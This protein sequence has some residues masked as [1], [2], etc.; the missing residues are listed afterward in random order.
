[1]AF[2]EN[3]DAY[4]YNAQT[5]ATTLNFVTLVAINTKFYKDLR[6][7]PSLHRRPGEAYWEWLGHRHWSLR[8]LFAKFLRR[9]VLHLDRLVPH[10]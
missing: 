2:S 7:V 8:K 1:M 3:G 6:L 10:S 4:Y 5:G 9:R